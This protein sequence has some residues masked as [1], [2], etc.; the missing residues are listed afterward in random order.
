MKRNGT[1]AFG[2]VVSSVLLIGF[3]SIVRDYN[4][5]DKIETI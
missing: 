5:G 3:L 2:V 4:K 1:I